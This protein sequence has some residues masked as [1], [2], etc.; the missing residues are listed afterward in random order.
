MSV[1]GMYKQLSKDVVLVEPSSQLGMSS[2]H[3]STNNFDIGMILKYIG[4]VD[5]IRP[6]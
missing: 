1:N 6:I 5:I 4:H 2:H 3:P